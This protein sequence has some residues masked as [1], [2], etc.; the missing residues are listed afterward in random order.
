MTFPPPTRQNSTSPPTT[1][2]KTLAS[3]PA[4]SPT[5]CSATPTR[6]IDRPSHHRADARRRPRRRRHPTVL[7]VGNSVAFAAESHAAARPS[8]REQ[9][10]PRRARGVERRVLPFLGRLVLSKRHQRISQT[11]S[12]HVMRLGGLHDLDKRLVETAAPQRDEHTFRS[13]EDPRPR[14]ARILRP[15]RCVQLAL[16][17]CGHPAPITHHIICGKKPIFPYLSC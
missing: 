6:R 5:F 1:A 13:V 11:H 8:N 7:G 3:T 9:V 4:R 12:A 15:T 10:P 2:P 16:K 14:A 17:S